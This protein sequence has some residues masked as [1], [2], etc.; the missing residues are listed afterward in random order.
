MAL[1]RSDPVSDEFLHHHRCSYAA[2]LQQLQPEPD[3]SEAGA[4][5]PLMAPAGVRN[6]GPRRS[7][8]QR[9]EPTGI[10]Q[11]PSYPEFACG[12]SKSPPSPAVAATTWKLK[13]PE[14]C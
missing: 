14:H 4:R 5:E 11:H 12:C 13:H 3:A 9:T 7:L 8:K 1:K 2:I 10:D 6:S